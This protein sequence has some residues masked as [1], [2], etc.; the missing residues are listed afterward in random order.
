MEAAKKKKAGGD[1]KADEEKKDEDAPMEEE[2]K[3]EEEEKEEE[4]V[5]ELTEEEK[6]L[7]FRKKDAP[8]LGQKVLAT[9]YAKF[10]LPEA[11]EG[12]DDIRYAWQPE[13]ECKEYMKKWVFERKLTQRVEELQ[14]SDWFKGKWTEWQKLVGTWK[15]KHGEWKDP[16]K[17]A[18]ALAK[19]KAEDAKKKQKAEKK[20]GE[21]KA[22]EKEPEPEEE[23][24]NMDINAEDLDVFAVD[25]V[26]DIGNGE[27]LF[28]N[29]VYE[30]WTLLS[31]RFELHLLAH[32]FKHDLADPER[33]TFHQQHLAYYYNKYYKKPFNLKSF[34]VEELKDLVDMVKDTVEISAKNSTIE[35][36]LSDDTPMDNFVKLTE[37][38]RRDR[39]RRLDA[40]DETALLKFTKPAPT[41]QG[42]GQGQRPQGGPQQRGN[43]GRPGSGGGY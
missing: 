24:Q 1:E 32:A 42:Q 38:H 14:P 15:R 12:F 10:T 31:L 33:P 23:E 41:G 11:D 8:D 35:S 3:E 22:E 37:D 18:T 17:K 40:G 9:S 43:E 39:Q 16:K 27:P 13:A 2:P 21:E 36:Q 19:K 4:I 26:T 34:G 7:T 25:D 6:K 20:D 30:D 29:F 5:A 28:A